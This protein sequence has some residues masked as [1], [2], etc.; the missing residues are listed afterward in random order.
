MTRG[1]EKILNSFLRSIHPYT[2]EK[3]E[4]EIKEHFTILGFL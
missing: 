1:E 4:E 2:Y 3:V